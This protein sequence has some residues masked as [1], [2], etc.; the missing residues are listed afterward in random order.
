MHCKLEFPIHIQICSQVVSEGTVALKRSSPLSFA[1]H[2][3]FKSQCCC[4]P[5]FSEALCVRADNL[6][7]RDQLFQI[8]TLPPLIYLLSQYPPPTLISHVHL[9]TCHMHIH[10]HTLTS[11]ACNK[12]LFHGHV[13]LRTQTRYIYS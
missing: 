7:N 4:S 9:H 3:E 11:R 5:G 1:Q 2:P 6:G 13:H 8:F 10:I 12:Y